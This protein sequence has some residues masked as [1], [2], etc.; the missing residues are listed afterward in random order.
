MTRLKIQL[1]SPFYLVELLG[2]LPDPLKHR[3]D[4]VEVVEDGEKDK[5]A[6]ED[7]GHFP[8]AED[9]NG[10]AVRQEADGADAHLRCECQSRLAQIEEKQ[11]KKFLYAS[12]LC[13]LISVA[14]LT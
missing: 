9:R 11:C 3:A 8:R 5:Q 4:D 2:V 7:A 12:L 14:A 13:M 6:V 1:H 10:Q